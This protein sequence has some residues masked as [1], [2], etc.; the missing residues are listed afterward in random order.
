MVYHARRKSCLFTQSINAAFRIH[1]FCQAASLEVVHS[2]L[3]EAPRCSKD[4]HFL[5]L[6]VAT[7][8]DVDIHVATGVPDVDPVQAKRRR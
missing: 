6:V 2:A 4:R 7:E 3:E 8:K 1:E 5:C